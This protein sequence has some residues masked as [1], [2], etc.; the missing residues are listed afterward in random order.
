MNT[1]Y[2]YKLKLKRDSF[3]IKNSTPFNLTFQTCKTVNV[4]VQLY[5]VKCYLD[6]LK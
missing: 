6:D 5:T 1:I 4:T 3:E 2:Q